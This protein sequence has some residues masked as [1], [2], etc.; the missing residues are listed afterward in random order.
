MKRYIL[1]DIV[2]ISDD[3]YLSRINVASDPN[4]RPDTLR[5]LSDDSRYEIRAEVG[6]NPN[7]PTDILT[8]LAEDDSEDVRV[9]VAQNPHTPEDILRRLCMD[10]DWFT[11]HAALK[12]LYGDLY[13]QT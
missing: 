2:D 1:A 9:C 3:G 8:K 5:K 6:F 7:T 4:T 12:N 13:G 10:T 11:R